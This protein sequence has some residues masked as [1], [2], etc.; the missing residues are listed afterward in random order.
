[1]ATGMDPG[2]AA[3]VDSAITAEPFDAAREKAARDAGWR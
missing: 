2:L 3:L 1:M